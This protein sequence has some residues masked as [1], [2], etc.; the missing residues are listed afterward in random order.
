[1]RAPVPTD[2]IRLASALSRAELSADNTSRDDSLTSSLI[3]RPICL[4]LDIRPRNFPAV[5]SKGNGNSFAGD[6][7]LREYRYCLGDL[8][9]LVIW[10]F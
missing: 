1:M 5:E 9:I 8:A 4:Q 10:K 7:S 6:P 3:V 2:G